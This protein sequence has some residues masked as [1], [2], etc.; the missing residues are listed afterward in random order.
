MIKEWGI[1]ESKINVVPLGS[2]VKPMTPRENFTGRKV[3]YVGKIEPRKGVDKLLEAFENCQERNS[4]H[5]I[6]YLWQDGLEG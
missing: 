2:F 5:R 6:D 1:S 4:G 3:L